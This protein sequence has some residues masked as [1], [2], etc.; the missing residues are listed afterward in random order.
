M[1]NEKFSSKLPHFT[2]DEN[3]DRVNTHSKNQAEE[4]NG[5]KT[6]HMNLVLKS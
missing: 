3:F 1:Q 6:T 4:L 2:M 5:L